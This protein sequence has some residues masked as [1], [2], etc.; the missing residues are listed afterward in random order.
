MPYIGNQ[1]GTGVRNRFIYTATASQT[2]FSGADDNSKTLKYA[3][4]A[5]VD[6]FL[7]GVCLVPGTDYTASTKTSIVLTQAA[8]LNDTLEVVAYDIATISDTVSK[9]DGG[10]FNGDLG[11]TNASPD[12]TLTNNTSEDTDGGRE[13]TV[14]F[15]G[16]QSGGEES[17][18]AQIQASHD[19]TADDQKGD[20]IFKTNDGS[21]NAAPTEAMRLDSLS[22]VSIG[23]GTS[24]VTSGWW[25]ST[26]NSMVSIENN[27]VNTGSKYVTL[28]IT[29][30][31]NDAE[32]PQ[33]GFSHSR[34]TT[35]DSKT[36]LQS[37][38]SIGTITFQGA[39]GSEYVE[40]ARIS[41]IVDGTPGANDMPTRLAFQVTHDGAA[42][43]TE[44]LRIDEDGLKFNGDTAAANALDDYEEGEHEVTLTPSGSG[45]ISVS[46]SNNDISYTKIGNRVHVSGQVLVSGSSSPVGYI[47]LSLPFAI[48]NSGTANT[49]RRVAGF[50]NVRYTSLNSNE[51]T[52]LGV[53]N[54]S[55]IRIYRANS[56]DIQS[57]SAEQFASVPGSTGIIV[58]VNFTYPTDS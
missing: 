54:E 49:Q 30:N 43:T 5:Y 28:G 3:D 21:D 55:L 35:H 33:L 1:P 22:R 14:T 9:A 34:G 42:T 48:K 39:D 46:G 41:A 23:S 52:L 45:T 8:S 57:S 53:E 29:R 6:V 37:G 24:S 16:L 15:K 58:I 36:V 4:S 11:I 2:T 12:I 47:K 27:G 32:A 50:V 26:L 19:A 44:K 56:T 17:T 31:T 20:L 51:Y 38:D 25:N 7:N 10:T 13:S 40:G 18:L